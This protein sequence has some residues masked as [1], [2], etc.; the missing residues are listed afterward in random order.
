MMKQVGL[1][2]M[3][4]YVIFNLK[5]HKRLHYSFLANEIS[6]KGLFYI[7]LKTYKNHFRYL[8]SCFNIHGTAPLKVNCQIIIIIIHF[9]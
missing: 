4:F 1:M 8:Q 6:Q 7:V 3:G 5:I 2:Y 9:I